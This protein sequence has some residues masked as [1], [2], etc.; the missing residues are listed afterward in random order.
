MGADLSR[1]YFMTWEAMAEYEIADTGKLDQ[2]VK[3]AGNPDLIIIDPPQN[4]LGE[5]DEHRNVEVRGVLMQ[6]VAWLNRQTRPVALLLITQVNKGGREVEAI[7]RIIGSVAWTATPRIAHTFGP[8]KDIPGAGLFACPKNN[9]GMI[10]KTLGFR[11]VPDGKRAYVEWGQE[12]EKTADEV[13]NGSKKEASRCI[14]AEAFLI[15]CF[16]QKREWLSEELFNLAE[17][18]K[19][20]RNAMFEAKKSLCLLK[21]QKVNNAWVW[22]VPPDWK[23][24]R[25]EEPEIEPDPD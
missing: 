11:I 19:I 18:R 1:V 16:N 24:L 10:P 8:E 7:N 22:S 25:P 2:L 3:Q 15:D 17:N 4:F 6:L 12:S 21:A 9:L 23:H 13:M 20:S 14:T 5:V